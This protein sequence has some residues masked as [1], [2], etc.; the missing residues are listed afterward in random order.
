[1]SSMMIL[2]NRPLSLPLFLAKGL[3]VFC[4]EWYGFKDW[5]LARFVVSWLK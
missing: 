2:H 3:T 5:L 1:M 4:G